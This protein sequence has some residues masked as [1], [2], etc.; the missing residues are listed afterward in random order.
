MKY[1]FEQ[2]LAIKQWYYLFD[3]R[4]KIVSYTF[5]EVEKY[6][7]ILIYLNEV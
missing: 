1:Y 7:S 5:L 4:D 3:N 2:N 6:A